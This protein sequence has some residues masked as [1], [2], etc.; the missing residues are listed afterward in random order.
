MKRSIVAFLSAL[1]FTAILSPVATAGEAE[2]ALK[3]ADA[4][5][6]AATTPAQIAPFYAKDAVFMGSSA[7]LIEGEA[8]IRKHLDAVANLPGMGKEAATEKVEV[9]SAGD[10]GFAIGKV[11]VALKADGGKTMVLPGKYLRVW[12]KQEGGWKVAAAFVNYIP[13]AEKSQ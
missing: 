11:Q 5:L 10:I 4:A 6:N 8:A 7:G 12:K 1:A 13:G 3:E 2:A 9:S